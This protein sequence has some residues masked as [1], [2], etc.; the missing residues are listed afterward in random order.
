MA[1]AL[2]PTDGTED[3]VA[4]AGGVKSNV[5]FGDMTVEFSPRTGDS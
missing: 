2:L 1:K 5:E 3:G 4:F